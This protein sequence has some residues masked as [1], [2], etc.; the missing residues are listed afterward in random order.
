MQISFA[1]F[2][3]N[4]GGIPNA[5]FEF[6]FSIVSDKVTYWAVRVPSDQLKMKLF[7][8]CLLLTFLSPQFLPGE[9]IWASLRVELQSLALQSGKPTIFGPKFR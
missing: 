9:T 2:D 5:V 3:R 8:S 7:E 4:I 1:S 6:R